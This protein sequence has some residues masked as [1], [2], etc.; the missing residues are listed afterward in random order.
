MSLGSL[1]H[2][3]G[4]TAVMGC[5]CAV[6]WED[7]RLIFDR[8]LRRRRDTGELHQPPSRALQ[9]QLT[10]LGSQI[11]GRVSRGVRPASIS[12]ARSA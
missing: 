9:N 11:C 10:D 12:A 1:T 4:W 5:Q 2:M 7:W 8:C 3:G 6:Y